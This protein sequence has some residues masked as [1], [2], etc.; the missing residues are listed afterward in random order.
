M[1]QVKIEI[2]SADFKEFSG[3]SA[4]GR[5][6]DM[7][8]QD[9]YLHGVGVYPEKFEVP[10]PARSGKEVPWRPY[11]PGFYTVA[12][13]SYQVYD[14]RLAIDNFV[15]VLEPLADAKDQPKP[16]AVG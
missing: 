3:T 5:P 1:S 9:A 10:L 15:L 16:R 6:Y 13:P 14:G 7:A 12:A 2:V 11:A 4:K 8:R